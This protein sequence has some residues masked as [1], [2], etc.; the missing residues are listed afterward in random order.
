MAAR[1]TWTTLSERVAAMQNNR[2]A[3]RRSST[4][5]PRL[6]AILLVLSC[7]LVGAMAMAASAQ[8]TTK[9]FSYTG[10]EQTFSV[11]SGVQSLQVRLIGGEGGHGDTVGGAG[12]EVLGSLEVTPGQLLYVEVGG[13]GGATGEG[14]FNGGGDANGIGA[15]GGGGASDIRLLPLAAGLTT[16]TRLV[17]AAGGG[18]GGGDGEDFG[19]EGG[20]A[21]SGGGVSGGGNEGGGAGTATEG[22]FGGFGCGEEGEGGE[23]GNGGEGG[24][25][26]GGNNGGGGG[27]GG[28][29]GGGGGSGGCSSGGG[30]GGGGSSLVPP[31]GSALTAA[32]GSKIEITY[33]EPIPS[34]PKTP[35][36]TPTTPTVP[37]TVLNSHPAKK[38]KTT[39]NRVKVKF[40]FSSS[41]AGAT[42]QCKLDKGAYAPCASPKRF[43]VKAG[44]HKFSVAAVN[45]GVVDP[46]PA[47]FKFKVIKT[48]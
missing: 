35:T 7:A 4:S 25:G 12:A 42:F 18:G 31:G 47:T 27:G 30:G 38:I 3:S 21:G 34:T 8:A 22:G 32:T 44:K 15:A 26:F 29:Y 9:V 45:G 39:K 19:G 37:D 40:T 16:D 11:P 1:L 28:Y 41:T 17:V 48:S 33:T 24:E 14:G 46:T 6:R 2:C 5:T 43:K 13:E 20:D 23:L 10:A 36:V